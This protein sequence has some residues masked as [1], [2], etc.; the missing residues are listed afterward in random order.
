MLHRRPGHAPRRGDFWRISPEGLLMLIRGYLED[1]SFYRERYG[2]EP[3]SFIDAF[4]TVR[5]L[6]ELVRHAAAFAERFS[7]A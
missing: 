1:R 5:S 3:G 7:G 2:M 6:T 4:L